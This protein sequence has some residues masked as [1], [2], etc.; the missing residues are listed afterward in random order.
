MIIP[1]VF[2]FSGGSPEALGKGPGLMFATLPQVFNSMSGGTVIGAAF[3]LLVFFAALTSSISLM[4]TVVSIIQDKLHLKRIPACLSVLGLSLLLGIP[5]SLGYSAWANVKI[6]GMQFL[7]F[8]D[9]AS[10]SVLMPIV[11]LATCIFVG[12]VLKPKAIIEEV[13]LTGRFKSRS[14]FTV[15]IRYVAPVS[16]LAIL[17]SSILSAFGIVSI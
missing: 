12:Y 3:F 4:E 8:F 15:V 7:D 13:E 5:S 2:T 16:I 9:F 6:L 17:T 11:A 1:A 14:M 10:N